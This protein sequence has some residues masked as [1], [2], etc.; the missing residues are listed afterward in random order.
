METLA[1]KA[2]KYECYWSLWLV[3]DC[4]D[5]SLKDRSVTAEGKDLEDWTDASWLAYL[6][7][8]IKSVRKS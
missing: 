6:R 5:V 8:I 4:E 3:L 7:G 1:L 2:W